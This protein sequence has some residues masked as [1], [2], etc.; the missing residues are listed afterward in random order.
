M[1]R[2]EKIE[3]LMEKIRE[4]DDETLDELMWYLEMDIASVLLDR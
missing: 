1:E 3:L 4:A 2:A